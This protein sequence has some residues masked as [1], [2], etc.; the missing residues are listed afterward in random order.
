M[1][2]NGGDDGSVCHAVFA[3]GRNVVILAPRDDG[4]LLGF[5]VLQVNWCCRWGCE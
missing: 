1:R 5:D 4:G 3:Q 2:G